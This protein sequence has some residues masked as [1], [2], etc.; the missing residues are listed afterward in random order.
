MIDLVKNY[1]I[2]ARR[3]KKSVI[4]ELLKLTNRPEMISF[5]GGLPDPTL[6]PKEDIKDI[7]AKVID[8]Y[9][10]SAFQYSTT[11]GEPQ[12]KRELIK[13]AKKD[14]LTINEDNI[15]ITVSSQQGLDLLGKVFIDPSDPVIVELPSYVGGLQ[16]FQGY[17]AHM[18]GIPTDHDGILVD[19]LEDTLGQLKGTEEHYKFIYLVPDFQNPAGVTLSLERRKKIIELSKKYDIL[20]IEDTPY[21]ELRFEGQSPPSLM[22]LDD[23]SNVVMLHTFSKIFVPG[24]R[25]GWVIAHADIIR[26]LAFA[27]QSVDLCT[28]AFT[29]LITYE[30]CRRGLLEEHIET[31]KRAY[32]KKRDVMLRALEEYMPKVEGVRWTRPQGGLFLWI[33]LPDHINCDKLFYE[34][35]EQ[36]VAFVIGSAFHCDGRGQNTMRLNFSYPTHE[37]IDEGIKRLAKVIKAKL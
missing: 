2:H 32:H 37:E 8:E 27:K 24:F 10:N 30:Y 28:P 1:G 21:R 16:V 29:Q 15:L 4:R 18:H 25:L 36:D 22:S 7:C 35:I 17:G 14:G 9:G 34:A 26:K 19:V 33:M 6:F 20:I 12:L 13:L 3:I 11:E 23:T 5:A 31:V